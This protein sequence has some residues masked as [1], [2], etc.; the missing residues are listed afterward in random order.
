MNISIK[1]SY[2]GT[3]SSDFSTKSSNVSIESSDFRANTNL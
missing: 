2:F 1:Y 3:E